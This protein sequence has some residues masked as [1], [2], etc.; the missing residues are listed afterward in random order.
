MR[1]IILSFLVIFM[2]CA[3]T[4]K[5]LTTSEINSLKEKIDSN[6]IEATFNWA[7]PLALNNNVR[8][9]EALLP[10]GSSSG[11]INLMGNSNF[12]RINKDSI[13]IDL[14]YYGQQQLSR[15]YN[16]DGGIKFEGS[17]DSVEKVF[18]SKKAA[19]ILKYVLK[20]KDESYNVVLT[21]YA[22]NKSNLSVSSSHRTNIS[23][24]GEWEIM[25]ETAK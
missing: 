20:A 19:Y 1:I 12:F 14:P 13:H 6:L 2:S 7:Q 15:G 18:N 4:K 24:R 10:P 5:A 22:S 3:T 25:K 8:G 23:Y 11:N 9:L 17:A 21:L 16:S